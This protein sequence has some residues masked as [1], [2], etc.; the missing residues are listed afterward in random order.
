MDLK[1][2]PISIGEMDALLENLEEEGYVFLDDDDKKVIKY[3]LEYEAI[4]KD[5]CDYIIG[6]DF[7]GFRAE[8]ITSMFKEKK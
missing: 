6:D 8:F 7:Y 1:K 5:G 2:L 3:L 4:E